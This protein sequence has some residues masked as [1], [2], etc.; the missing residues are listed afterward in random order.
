[1]GILLWLLLGLIAGW[2]ASVIMGTNSQQGMLMDIILGVVGAFAG[3]L[4]MNIFGQA[5][6]SGFNLYSLF[7]ATLGAIALIWLGRMLRTTT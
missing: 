6:V 4:L 5:G 1:M 3:G 7:V 2:L